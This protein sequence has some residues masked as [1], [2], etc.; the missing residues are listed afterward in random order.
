MNS[1]IGCLLDEQ[2]QVWGCT[3]SSI[4]VVEIVNGEEN[5]VKFSDVILYI[6]LLNSKY[7]SFK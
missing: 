3:D 7:F 2:S 1:G 4:Q 6:F 5:P